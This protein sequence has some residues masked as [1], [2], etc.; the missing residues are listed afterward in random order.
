MGLSAGRGVEQSIGARLGENVER[1]R[2]LTSLGV[3]DVAE[4]VRGVGRELSDEVSAVP[5]QVTL[6]SVEDRDG[7]GAARRDATATH[8]GHVA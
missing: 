1:V 6:L 2:G 8:A 3:E 5:H 4:A 7:P